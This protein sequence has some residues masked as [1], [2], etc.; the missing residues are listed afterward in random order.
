LDKAY[1]ISAGLADDQSQNQLAIQ[2]LTEIIMRTMSKNAAGDSLAAIELE[3]ERNA[4]VSHYA[5]LQQSIV[6]DLLHP[7]SLI[8]ADELAA[9]LLSESVTGFRAAID[10]FDSAQLNEINHE[11]ANIKQL[12]E[13]GEKFELLHNILTNSNN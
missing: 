5:L 7:D 10:L 13:D 9:T 4:R 3:Q 1:E 11:L 12:P 6:A 8:E 2:Q